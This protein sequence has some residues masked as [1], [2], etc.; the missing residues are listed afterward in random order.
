MGIINTKIHRK[1]DI[2][3]L[4]DNFKRTGSGHFYYVYETSNGYRKAN[5]CLQCTSVQDERDQLIMIAI[6]QGEGKNI[7]FTKIK[8]LNIF[9]VPDNAFITQNYRGY[10]E[11]DSELSKLIEAAVM[12]RLHTH[13]FDNCQFNPVT[14]WIRDWNNRMSQNY[15][16]NPGG[17]EEEGISQE[18]KN[19]DLPLEIALNS[20][21][22]AELQKLNMIIFDN[23]GTKNL[24]T[25]SQMKT[26]YEDLHIFI[27][28]FSSYREDVYNIVKTI[29]EINSF[30]NITDYANNQGVNR[31]TMFYRVRRMYAE[32]F[33]KFNTI[34]L[35]TDVHNK[36]YT[37]IQISKLN[38]DN[39]HM[40]KAFFK[41]LKKE[42]YEGVIKLIDEYIRLAK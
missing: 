10:I 5:L 7:I 21:D 38:K 31:Q 12:D 1:G 25:I 42:K 37:D 18:T 33:D 14:E 22:F 34:P 36:K 29:T 39:L 41:S 9:E 23:S 19:E 4:T 8:P 16:E 35:P 13:Q 11:Q 17:L 26:V 3:F 40:L 27:E 15:S 2:F 28:E 24:K 32:L 6:N 20:E 30:D